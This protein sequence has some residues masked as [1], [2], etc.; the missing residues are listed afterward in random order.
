MKHVS[1][2]VLTAVVLSLPL[3]AEPPTIHNAPTHQ[4][5]AAALQ[6]QQQV[7][8][9]APQDE[10]VLPDPSVASRPQD[11]LA[12]ADMLCYRGYATLVPKRAILQIPENLADRVGAK[13]GVKLLNWPEFYAM[14]RS[15]I[16]TQEV[17][18]AQSQ[19]KDAFDP[20]VQ[21]RMVKSGN[22][23]VATFQTGPISVIPVPV[24]EEP[25]PAQP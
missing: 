11:L 25:A 21:T 19:G 13:P 10:K 20:E 5:L 22:L 7:K 2:C 9:A 16:G 8:A 17:S 15:W 14:N 12:R 6:K 18:R 24:P 23:I 1:K 4:Q 3:R